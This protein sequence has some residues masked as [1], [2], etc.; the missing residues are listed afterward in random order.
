[1]SIAGTTTIAEDKKLSINCNNMT[2]SMTGAMPFADQNAVYEQSNGL[3][4]VTNE[5][6]S[7]SL[8]VTLSNVTAKVKNLVVEN[9]TLEDS[10]VEASDGNVG[11]NGGTGKVTKLMIL[12]TSTVA[13]NTIGA[14]PAR[15]R[16][17]NRKAMRSMPR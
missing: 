11:S 1:M 15:I 9:L 6:N 17:L 10:A 7:N 5:I 12:G 13:A 16:R 4:N 8:D 14:F 2:V 3:W